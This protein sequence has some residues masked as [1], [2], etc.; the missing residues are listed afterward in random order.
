[1][2]HPTYGTLDK[3]DIYSIIVYLRQLAP[4]EFTP[5]VSKADFPMNLILNTIPQPAQFTNKPTQTDQI[6]WGA[7]LTKAAA[8]SDCHTKQEKGK[9]VGAYMAG[10]FE[11][12]FPDG[13]IL[14]SPNITPD[15]QT[16]IGQMTE[17]AFVQRFRQYADSNYHPIAL[18]PDDFQTVMPWMMYGKMNETD[19]KAIYAYLM[20]IEPANNK[21]VKLS[22]P[23]S[24]LD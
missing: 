23:L 11:F 4:V 18:A 19:L 14:R 17:E 16:G 21:I 8:C 2:P 22:K 12:K 24:M 15:N 9:V 3:E 7:Y 5:D 6:A 20:S 10:G 13:R 1:M